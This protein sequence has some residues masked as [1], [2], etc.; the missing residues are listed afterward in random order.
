MTRFTNT[1]AAALGLALGLA[2]AASAQSLPS[3]LDRG[4]GQQTWQ[5]A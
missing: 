1:V 2:G 4:H 3:A 5:N